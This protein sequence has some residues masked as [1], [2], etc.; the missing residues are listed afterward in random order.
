M[1]QDNI[2]STTYSHILKSVDNLT[3]YDFQ[4]HLLASYI[5]IYEKKIALLQRYN[6][7]WIDNYHI[8]DTLNIPKS[9]F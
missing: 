8:N 2:L 4:V 1:T 5:H 6:F 3:Y 9:C 7:T